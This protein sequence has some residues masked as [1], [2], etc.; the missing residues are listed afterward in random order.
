MPRLHLIEIHDQPWCPTSLRDACTDYLRFTINLAK[1]YEPVAS[2]LKNAMAKSRSHRVVDLCSGGGGP[3]LTLIE[4]FSDDELKEVCLTDL[5]P[6]ITAFREVADNVGERV[7][8]NEIPVDA[9]D[10]AESLTGFRTLF[11]SFHHFRPARAKEILADAVRKRQG[12]GIFEMTARSPVQIIPILF[13]PLF[14]ILVSPFMGPFRWSRMFWT[15]VIPLLPFIV[16]VDGVV[17]C[18]RTYSPAELRALTEEFETFEW[19]MGLLKGV[20]LL[21]ITYLIGTPKD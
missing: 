9:T 16:C 21:K 17:S 5:F 11:S 4:T 10:M 12:I 20:G 3:W 15:Y 1:I 18:L 19:E 13:S 8:Y 2:P 14:V 6:N 7:T